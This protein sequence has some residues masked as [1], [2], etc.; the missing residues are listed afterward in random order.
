VIDDLL[1]L[2]VAA[3]GVT[4]RVKVAPR[5][6]RSS[7]NGVHDGALKVSL[8]APPVEGAAN[9]ALCALLSERLRVPK[10]AIE[11][12]QGQQSKLKTVRIMGVSEA[13]VRALAVGK[14]TP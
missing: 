3:D 10:R 14:T 5:A 4:L 11:I 1:E 8:T 9:T 13:Q 7:V 6:S 2:K 12:T